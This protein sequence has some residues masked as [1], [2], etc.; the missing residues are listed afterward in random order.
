MQ[1]VSNYDKDG[2]CYAYGKG[3]EALLRSLFDAK[4][5]ETKSSTQEEDKYLHADFFFKGKDER[6]YSIDVKGMKKLNRSD[7]A[8]QDEWAVVEFVNT[9]GYEGWAV[10]GAHIIAFERESDFVLIKRTDLLA[11]CEERVDK[12]VRASSA[13]DAQYICYSRPNRLDLIAMI[14]IEDLPRD[15]I[16]TL[17][18]FL[19]VFLEEGDPR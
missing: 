14:K 15:Q 10:K 7:E 1:R 11:F 3:V 13:G 9:H 2:A 17:E 5:Y 18:K 19:N 12:S 16:K 6:W 4:G 8:R